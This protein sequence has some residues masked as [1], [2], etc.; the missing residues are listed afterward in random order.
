MTIKKVLI[1]NRGEI[2]VRIIR[3]L[4]NLGLYSV[5]VYSDA[6]RTSPSCKGVSSPEE[7]RKA[8]TKTSMK[9]PIDVRELFNLF[10]SETKFLIEKPKEIVTAIARTT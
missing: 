2:A 9:A 7:N 6:D 10:L 1:A 8:I 3:T 4:K 5:A